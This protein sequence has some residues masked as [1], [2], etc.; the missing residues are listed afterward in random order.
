MGTP[1]PGYRCCDRDSY[2]LWLLCV[3][4]QQ[5]HLRYTI[6]SRALSTLDACRLSLPTHC[7]LVVA[8]ALLSPTTSAWLFVCLTCSWI[9]TYAGNGTDGTHSTTGPPHDTAACPGDSVC[10][11]YFSL[12]CFTSPTN[13]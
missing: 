7:G 1:E 4:D 3:F 9:G 2:R 12:L 6:T 10:H 8:A 5:Q 13:H 11:L